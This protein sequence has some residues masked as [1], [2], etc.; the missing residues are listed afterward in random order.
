MKCKV[1]AGV[2]LCQR[3]EP[4]GPRQ[5]GS[6]ARIGTNRGLCG[7][8]RPPSTRAVLAGRCHPLAVSNSAVPVPP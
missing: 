3:R 7:R 6:A 8:Y 2:V 1:L 4:A 5:P